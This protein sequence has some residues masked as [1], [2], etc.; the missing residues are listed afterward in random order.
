MFKNV[1]LFG[2]LLLVIVMVFSGCSSTEEPMEVMEEVETD[3]G[4]NTELTE[5]ALAVTEEA[6]EF[7]AS[8]E[9]M[10]NLD[11]ST[12]LDSNGFYENVVASQFVEDFEFNTIE[13]PAEIHTVSEATLQAEIDN[14]MTGFETLIQVT[15]RAIVDGDTINLDFVGSVDGVEFEG[16]S[17]NGSGTEVTIGVTNFIDDFLQQLIGHTPGEV[18]DIEVTFPEDYGVDTLN[19]KEAIFAITLNYISDSI[20]PELTDAF[21]QENL[22]P[23]YEWTTVDEMKAEMMTGISEMAVMNYVQTYVIGKA[24]VT[25]VPEEVLTYQKNSMM[26][27]Y[28]STASSYGMT[29]TEFLTSNFGIAT[30]EE[31]YESATQDLTDMSNNSLVVQAIAEEANLSVSEEVLRDFFINVNGSGDYTEFEGIYGIE[32]LKYTVLQQMVMDYLVEKAELL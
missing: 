1:K 7:V 18:F 6:A 26:N 10:L 12:G 11:Y 13:V 16:G 8:N 2:M 29:M 5:E 19:G 32:F 17:T 28:Q 22:A 24:I 20:T 30:I 9:A 23:A 4:E 21:V 14:L 31:L 3:S 15:D 25:S 27:Y